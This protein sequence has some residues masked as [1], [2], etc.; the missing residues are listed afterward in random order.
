MFSLQNE[1]IEIQ[2]S[3]RNSPRTLTAQ[4]LLQCACNYTEQ[5]GCVFSLGGGLFACLFFLTFLVPETVGCY[6]LTSKAGKQTA[7]S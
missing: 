5:K 1:T 2:L 6:D 3:A 4:S 7:I